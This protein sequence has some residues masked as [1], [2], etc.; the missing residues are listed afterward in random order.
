[1]SPSSRSRLRRSPVGR[2]D[3]FSRRWPFAGCLV[4]FGYVA[5]RAAIDGHP[6]AAGVFGLL[7]VLA[8]LGLAV[9]LRTSDDDA[10]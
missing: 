7:T 10:A 1:M 8:I 9:A 5:A 3:E 6:L 2:L 4:G